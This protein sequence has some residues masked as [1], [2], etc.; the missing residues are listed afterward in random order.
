MDK[1]LRRAEKYVFFKTGYKR[2][3]GEVLGGREIYLKECTAQS[4]EIK[5]Y[6]VN[7]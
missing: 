5:Y 2:R 4:Y 6:S 7:N 3:G 1:D